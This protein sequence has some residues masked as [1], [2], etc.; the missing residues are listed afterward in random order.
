MLY[1]YAATSG[2]IWSE[3]HNQGRALGSITDQYLTF[4]KEMATV[5]EPRG[6]VFH[7]FDSAIK[8]FSDHP[9]PAWTS[10][11]LIH[12]DPIVLDWKR[13]FLSAVSENTPNE[14]R[15]QVENYYST[16]D[17]RDVATIVGHEITHHLAV[18]S[19][20]WDHEINDAMWFEEGMCFYLPRKKILSTERFEALMHVEDLLIQEHK[21]QFGRHPVWQFG[22][23]DDGSGFVAA[24]FDY[25]RAI[26]VV[27]RIVEDHASGDVL[28]VLQ[29]FEYWVEHASA[30]QRFFNFVTEN[31]NIP[32]ANT[33]EYL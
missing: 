24:L 11:E 21:Q 31:L 12:V 26:S 32:E 20:T 29:L 17:L 19:P 23:S 18:F 22:V 13:I 9:L 15:A 33:L 27:R 5:H 4:L 1:S 3:V 14:I 30:E 28:K 25:W 6:I 16:L 2:D 10:G 8:V 7:D